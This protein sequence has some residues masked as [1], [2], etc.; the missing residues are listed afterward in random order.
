[1]ERSAGLVAALL[2]VL[3]AGAAYLPVDPG[4]PAVRIAYM[5]ADADP[6]V[7][8]TSA[9]CAAAVPGG[10]QAPVLVT[11]DPA[12]AAE[13]AGLPA[14]DLPSAGRAPLPGHPAYVIYTSGSTGQPAGVVVPHRNVVNLVLWAV[15]A[16]GR[17]GCP[18]CSPL[19]RLALTSRCSRSFPAWWRGGASR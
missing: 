1:M 9:G 2:G 11:D 3:K 19:L 15:A 7:V 10:V 13:L 17:G 12:F 16:F 8:I 4:Y 6:G 5:L 18:G 14:A